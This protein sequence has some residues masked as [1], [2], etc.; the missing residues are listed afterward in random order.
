MRGDDPHHFRSRNSLGHLPLAAHREPRLCA[1]LHPPHLGDV[2][3]KEARVEAFLERVNFQLVK[4]IVV[5]SFARRGTEVPWLYV[6][7][8]A[9]LDTSLAGEF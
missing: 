3:R 2:L 6:I 4:Y 5:A 8:A 1:S 9:D 7:T